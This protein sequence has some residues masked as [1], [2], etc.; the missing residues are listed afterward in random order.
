[1]DCS[2]YGF[3]PIET[4][5]EVEKAYIYRDASFIVA[6]PSDAFSKKLSDWMEEAQGQTIIAGQISK[7]LGTVNQSHVLFV[8]NVQDEVRLVC[9]STSKR[10]RAIEFLDYA[11]AEFGL[12]KGD[13]ASASG[14]ISSTILNVQMSAK[15][16][17]DGMEYMLHTVQA[18]YEQCQWIDASAYG[19]AHAEEIVLFSQYI[20]KHIAWAYVKSTDIVEEGQR[21]VIKSLENASG[22]SV[23][24]RENVYIM[25]GCRGEVYDIVR[26]K[27]E[28][29]Y[30]A[31]NEPLDVF[32][33]MMDFMP[34]TQIASTGEYVMLDDKAFLCYPKAGNGIYAKQLEQRT[35]IFPKDNSGDYY[36]GRAGDYMAVRV[37]DIED[38]YVIQQDVFVQTYEEK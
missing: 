35:K 11:I 25:I 29:T 16:I 31:T 22:L 9:G 37:D 19:R 33:Q 36:L 10:V 30:D 38:V 28:R 15:D 27:F 6:Q 26:E 18:Y 5:D 14:R 2:K 4:T 12:V 34:E 13:A 17:T 32:E 7:W 1:M 3:I 24:A 8:W 21:F 20:K 23:Q